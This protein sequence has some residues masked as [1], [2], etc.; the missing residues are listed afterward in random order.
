MKLNDEGEARLTEFS[1][2]ELSRVCDNL[3]IDV[4]EEELVE[5]CNSALDLMKYN[6]NPVLV[7]DAESKLSSEAYTLAIELIE[8]VQR[9]YNKDYI[10]QCE[11]NEPDS[12]LALCGR[13]KA[14]LLK[15]NPYAL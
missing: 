3:N 6:A 7:I 1:Y 13:L 15:S 8:R 9:V 14:S 5:V 4:P 2:R 10:Q 12:L 11:E